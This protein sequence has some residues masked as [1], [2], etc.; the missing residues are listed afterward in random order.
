MSGLSS[1]VIGLRTQK[2]AFP[3]RHNTN[4]K[5]DNLE[6]KPFRAFGLGKGK[7]ALSKSVPASLHGLRP[8]ILE[9]TRE[10]KRERLE[11]RR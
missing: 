1:D 7:A 10:S 3:E 4:L 6:K 2:S 9:S 8:S 11:K 5:T